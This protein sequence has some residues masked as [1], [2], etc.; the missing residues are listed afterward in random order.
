MHWLEEIDSTNAEA[1][2]LGAK[3]EPGGLWIVADRQSEGRGRSGRT[4][5]SRPGN[6]HASLLLRDLAPMEKASQLAL[7]AAVAVHDA[8]AKAL[9]SRDVHLE[10]GR[11]E[12]KWPNDLLLGRRKVG[13]ILIESS[14]AR[15]SNI[16]VVGIGLNLAHH[17]QGVAQEADHLGSLGAAISPSE[18]LAFLSPSMQEWL[19]IWGLGEGF[20]QVREAWLARGLPVG[21]PLVVNA[22]AGPQ[23]GRFGGLDSSGALVIQKDD[24]SSATFTFGDVS[25]PS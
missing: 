1:L 6:L 20:G 13:G 14:V 24:G 2:R 22:A 5:I 16:A 23:R 8:V 18:M 4:W 9:S 12:L 10:A 19:A 15:A 11:L 25:L 3:G 17:P 7:V 21:S